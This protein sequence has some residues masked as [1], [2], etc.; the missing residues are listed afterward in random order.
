M[1]YNAFDPRPQGA[2]LCITANLFENR[3]KGILH[4]FTGSFRIIGHPTAYI[5]H[6]ISILL[7][8]PVL[9][10]PASCKTTRYQVQFT[11]KVQRVWMICA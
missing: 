1:N 7:I 10:I 8:K 11:L 2:L 9:R 5:V 4:H 6:G 3:H